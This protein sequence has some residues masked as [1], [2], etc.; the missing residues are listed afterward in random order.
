MTVAGCDWLLKRWDEL[1]FRLENGDP[2]VMEDVWKMVRLL[3]KMAIEMK[4]DFQVALLVLSWP[5]W[6]SSPPLHLNPSGSP[7]LPRR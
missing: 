6:L 7:R 4:D 5:A 2:W 1:P 3:G